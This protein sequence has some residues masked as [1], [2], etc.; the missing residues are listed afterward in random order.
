M[1]IA[2]HHAEWLSLLEIS[3]PFLT[4]NTLSR[5]F[6]QGVDMIEPARASELRAAY[7]EW[8]VEAPHDPRFH[9]Q[10]VL[11]VL[12]TLL[13][14]D[15]TVL[16]E[17]QAI[18]EP[19]HYTAVEHGGERI[20]PTFILHERRQPNMVRAMVSVY[21]PDVALEKSLPRALWAAS[22]AARM[23]ALLHATGV[24]IGLVTNGEQWM[25]VSASKT[26]MAGFIS[27]Y[28]DLWNEERLTLRAFVSLLEARRFFGV[29]DEDTLE[30]M[31]DQSA[32]DAQEV[33][34]QLGM[35]VRQA[36]EILVRA[37]DRCDQDM[38]GALLDGVS[39]S[40]LYEAAL[41]VMMRL[42]FLLSA[43]ERGL[44][45]LGDELYDQ[46]YAISTLRA[47]LREAADR[48]GEEVLERRSDAW[49]RLLATFRLVYHGA[50]HQD[51]KLPA[52]GGSLFDPGRFPFL[53]GAQTGT[54]PHIDNRTVLHLLDALQILQTRGEA[55]RL[56]F[57]ALD[58][59]QIG[60]VYEGLL[61]HE[62]RRAEGVMLG[63][64]GKLEP[65]ISL[66][67]LE[68]QSDITKYLKDMT[69]K[70]ET[71]IKNAL[72]KAPD[73][74]RLR[75][76]FEHSCRSDRALFDRVMPYLNLLRDDEFGSPLVIHPGS[77]YVTSG[78]ERR[79]TGT[80]YTPRALTEPIVE[81]TLAPLV[82]RGV[83]EGLP[84]EAWELKA[85]HEI[86]SLKVCD[87]AMGSGAFLVQTCR[88][89][90]ARLIEAWEK[91]LTLNSS[92]SVR[93]SRGEGLEDTPSSPSLLPAAGEG[94]QSTPLHED[95]EGPG[96]RQ[97]RMR[98]EITP[99]LK[100]R[101][102][103]VARLFRKEPTR[104][105]D[106]LWQAIRDRRLD[107][108]K[109]RRQQPIGPFVVDFF[110]PSENL[111]VEVD[112]GI[113]Q[114]QQEADAQRQSLIESAGYRF[115]RLSA[116][117]VETNLDSALRQI[118]AA[119]LNPLTLNPSSPRPSRGE[120]LEDAPSSPT[121]LPKAGKSTPLHADHEGLPSPQAQREGEGQ[122]VR[123]IPRLTIY[124]EPPT[125]ALTEILIPD[126]PNERMTLA[127][128]LIADRCLYGVDKNPLAVEMAKLSLW[129]TT[130]AKGRPFTFLDHALKCG[131]SLLGVSLRQL[132]LWNLDPDADDVPLFRIRLGERIDEIVGLRLQLE[133]FTVNSVRDQ[134]E[135]ARLHREAEMRLNDLRTAADLL[136]ASYLVEEVK[137]KQRSDLRLRLL[138][139]VMNG[140]DLTAAD[141][142][143]LS[144]V[145]ERHR[146]FHWELEFPEV[147]ISPL[148]LNPS[149][150]A[151]PSRGEG[152]E[153]APSSPSL[154][155][156]AGEGSQQKLPS[157]QAKRD[158]EGPGVRPSSPRHADGEG[159]GV[160]TGFDAVVGNP[161]FQGG[162][163]L[164]GLFGTP[165]RDYLVNHIAGGQKGSADLCAYFF[166]RAY[167][168]LRAGGA[169]G[170]IAT[171]T[172]AQ[173][174]TREV[175]LVQLDQAGAAIYRAANNLTWPGA[176][177]VVVD[178]VHVYKGAYRGARCLDD[179]PV[180]FITPLLDDIAVDGH[181]LPRRL[182]AN[183]GKS[184]QGSI[185]LGMGFV[186][187]PEEAQALI[188]KDPRS[189]DVLFP[190]L[191][192]E[193]LN[194]HPEQ[195]P[196][197]WVINFFDWSEEQ[198]M[199][200]PDCYAIV[201]EKVKPERDAYD[202]SR[203]SWNKTVK[204]NWWLY[205]AWR[206]SL[207]STIAPLRRVL[208]V[209][210][211]SKTL[212]FAF[213]PKGI[214]YSMMTVVFSLEHGCYLA[215]MQSSVHQSWVRQ[216]ASTMKQDTRYTPVD[217]FETFPFP[218]DEALASLEGIGETYHE[219]RRQIMRARWEGL[220]D[221]Y[222]RFHNPDERSADIQ[223][224]REL[225]R[226]MDEAVAA[227]Y[228]WDDLDLAHDF[229][230]TAQ[231]VRYT[232]S[233]A[234]RREVL[235]RLLALNFARYEEEQRLGVGL[236]AKK[237]RKKPSPPAPLPQGE[238]GESAS[239]G[240][241]EERLES[242]P[243]RED[244]EGRGGEDNDP[245]APPPEQQS[246]W[247]DGE[248]KQKR[249]L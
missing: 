249:L 102:V 201:R 100:Q 231:G 232:I 107:G 149:P 35:Q 214:V 66:D 114:T 208:V 47:Q 173:G 209:A 81:H 178:V 224:L 3:G 143:K 179:Q 186:L 168:L 137:D 17:G 99:E 125:G 91:A 142:E 127:L 4:L 10:W 109:F 124:G 181:Y 217:V 38:R 46:N 117:L 77:V 28:A 203:N 206:K 24:Q 112:G 245:N 83:A 120:G 140:E 238:R 193:D 67:A 56:S 195:Q 39:E 86:L 130:L 151:R 211:T 194:S 110:C 48:M 215:L 116:E 74:E 235:R 64:D 30:A 76:L 216:Y 103:E 156:A 198:A 90:A 72:K 113:H 87:M 165:Y 158:G 36:V 182:L 60:H 1:S 45:L 123:V 54:P 236:D 244:G 191:N 33:T 153:N 248:P 163:H 233:E 27:W 184:F 70:G 82:Y 155:P 242:S 19:F 185:V 204:T 80:H 71:A 189:R 6:P 213:V 11:Y 210:Q 129:L 183:A 8:S 14:W 148:T 44:F 15:D 229:Y 63:F 29:A 68:A 9:R 136:A 157:P 18:P 88:Y 41:T 167:R 89:L 12:Q 145:F 95:E 164:T 79:A 196:S 132:R 147:F 241:W 32:D 227:A 52:Y 105:E 221:T 169:F 61:D 223:H 31:L 37:L 20:R 222:N 119:F 122:G 226:Q 175:G 73:G 126:D 111:V 230:E 69:G 58:I 26:G 2:K 93:S 51:L 171:N 98:L 177:A 118:R 200:Y 134:Q 166:L 146:P 13:G 187:T 180:A 135:K 104:S 243:L 144:P 106:I 23:L 97:V 218:S 154:L 78:T 131:D 94:G 207:H 34:D 240:E 138:N 53:E 42:V 150:S 161:P 92:P 133:G 212:A 170:L 22:P 141:R 152:L 57:R 65:E 246:L 188:D 174:D 220:T 202:G 59:E 160:R 228:G 96:M 159:P 49:S 176:A 40:R 139:A 237:G 247:D 43:E 75:R 219:T 162:Q 21:T 7:E 108:R 190:Y 121:L 25:L 172:I 62:A 85:P 16:A 84:P 205:G 5:V 192:G 55:R 239:S 225:H 115:V 197:R 199:Q 234:A 101:M 50:S 128:R